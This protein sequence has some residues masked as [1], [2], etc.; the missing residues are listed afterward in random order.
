M[1]RRPDYIL[2]LLIAALLVAGL[3]I[4]ASA[5]VSISYK[6]FGSTSRY[7]L[8]QLLSGVLVGVAGFMVAQWVPYT[9]WRRV[10][11]PLLL[12]TLI[13]LAAVFT[14]QFG[15]GAGGA[16]RWIHYRFLFFQPSELAKLTLAMYLA[17]FF[18]KTKDRFADFWRA[19]FP[20]TLV[21]GAIIVL[22]ALE[23]D[24]G[25]LGIIV[26]MTGILFFAA[27]GTIR[28]MGYMAAVALALFF[29]LIKTAPYRFNRFL[30]FLHPEIDPKG[31]SYQIQQALIAIGSGGI[32]GLG[33]GESRQKY[34]FLPETVGD[35]IFAITAEELGF[36]GAAA[37][38]A[39]FTLFAL[40]ALRVASRAPDLFGKYLCI[41]IASWI[42]L[43]AFVNMAAIIGLIPLTG[44]TL[45]FVSYGGSSLAL[46][47]TACGILVNISKHAKQ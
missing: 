9:F 28:H 33:F 13:L 3:L 10:S 15:F 20:F 41:G 43:Q 34:S 24:L 35:S 40:R 32:W 4:L 5:S 23:P 37:L 31:I 16:R 1:R 39:L 47:L 7:I 27:G 18:A 30:V 22:I 29:V 42:T 46:T 44:V 36:I 19:V 26:G 11:V 6:T 38:V 17:A 45:P 21:S 2:I 14:T 25:T 12:L 8:N